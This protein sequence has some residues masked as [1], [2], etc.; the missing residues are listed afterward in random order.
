ME[1]YCGDCKHESKRVSEE[2]CEECMSSLGFTEW[3]AK[4]E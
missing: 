1:K 2:P 4:D 3:E